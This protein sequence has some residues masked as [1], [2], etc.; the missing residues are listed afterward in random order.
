MPPMNAT[1]TK[2]GLIGALVFSMLAL[3]AFAGPGTGRNAD[4]RAGRDQVDKRGRIPTGASRHD[5]FKVAGRSGVRK[6]LGIQLHIGSGPIVARHREPARYET[7]TET[8]LVE[9]AH[10]E[11][12]TKTVLVREGRWEDR[13]I[14]GRR[15]ILRYSRGNLHEVQVTPARVGK[16]WCPPVYETRTVRVLVPARYET[17]TIRVPVN[18]RRDAG[19]GHDKPAAQRAVG[20]GLQ[21][22]G[23]ILSR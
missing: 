23:Q 1:K 12:R 19:R 21:I 3:P 20:I 13:L 15:E 14:P 10:Y 7:R 4:F 6:D 18:D 8:V 2:L 16:V 5:R 9:R 11:T 17:R 22:L